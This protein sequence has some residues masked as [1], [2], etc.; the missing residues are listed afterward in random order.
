[1]SGG[2]GA[3]VLGASKDMFIRRTY[4]FH[5]FLRQ[6]DG[7]AVNTRIALNPYCQISGTL[8]PR[9]RL[10]LSSV[11]KSPGERSRGGRQAW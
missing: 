3:V 10:R 2:A 8:G 5:P 7:S 4:G 11:S 6:T 1:M 9:T